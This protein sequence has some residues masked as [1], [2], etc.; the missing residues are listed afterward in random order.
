M[1]FLGHGGTQKDPV[2]PWYFQINGVKATLMC[3]TFYNRNVAGET[4]EAHV[5][6][7]LSGEG[8][9]KN[10][11]LDY[12]A[13]AVLFFDVLFKGANPGDANWAIWA[14][15]NPEVKKNPHFNSDALALYNAALKLAPK[16]PKSFFAPF[17]LYTPIAGTESCKKCGLPQEFIG[18]NPK[19]AVPEPGALA[20]MGTGLVAIAGLV[21]KRLARSP[22]HRI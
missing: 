13:A 19:L 18:Y 17:L 2:Y 16:L 15:F 12:K 21:R 7:I 6:N 1:K 3:D 22:G 5:S 14:L 9:F 11:L 10:K 8:L 20:L 4:W